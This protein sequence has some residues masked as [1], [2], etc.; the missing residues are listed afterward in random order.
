MSGTLLETRAKRR[1]AGI[2][3]LDAMSTVCLLEAM[4][5]AVET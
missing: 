1:E 4:P 3:G 5:Q 2:E